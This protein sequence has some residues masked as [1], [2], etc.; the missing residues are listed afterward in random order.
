MCVCV[1]LFAV[2]DRWCGVASVVFMCVVWC[3]CVQNKAERD[4]STIERIL[5]QDSLVGSPSANDAIF[6]TR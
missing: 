6:L 2:F 1:C 3:C 5:S 4:D